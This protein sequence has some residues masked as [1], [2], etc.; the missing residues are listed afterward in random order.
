MNNTWKDIIYEI[1]LWSG[2]K[3][4][5]PLHEPIFEGN[6]KRYVNDCLDTGWVSS[7]GKY[8][9]RLE[10]QLAEFT[11]VKKAIAVVNGTAALHIALKLAGVQEDDE[12]LIPSLTFIATANAVNYC[13]AIPH[14]VDV[15]EYTLGIDPLALKEYLKSNALLRDGV[16]INKNTGRPIR[17]V[18]PMHTFGHP[19][20]LDILKTVADEYR[21]V[22]VEDA[23]ESIGSYY[24]GRHTGNIGKLAAVSFNGNKIIT[25]GGG[26]AILTNDED[27]ASYAKH[28]TTTAKVLHRWEYTHD[29]VGFNYRMPNINAALG[30]AQLEQLPLFLKQKRNLT[31][32]YHTLFSTFEGISLFTEPDFAESNYWLQTLILDEKYHKRDEILTLLNDNGI[33][34]R[35]IWTPLHK[36][37][38]YKHCP[39]AKL[40]ITSKL[41]SRVINIPSSPYLEKC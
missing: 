7:V 16:C 10:E 35:P 5:V 22:I 33:M 1:K 29:E 32:K 23:A 18:V 14:F 24:K 34:A 8:V 25:T 38:P 37:K 3:D 2:G 17:A 40:S 30:C 21:L 26:G 11:G 27:L 41:E 13:G 12:V 6:A 19:V 20:N 4:F 9:E 36:L 39:S 28:L 31:E 15:E